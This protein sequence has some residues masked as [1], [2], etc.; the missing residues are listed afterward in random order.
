[1]SS[2]PPETLTLRAYREHD[3][4]QVAELFEA[5]SL[6]AYGVSDQP[7]DELLKYFTA[8]TTNVE[9]DVRLA[10]EGD[11][12]VGYVDADSQ[13][14]ASWWSDVRVAP[15]EDTPRIVPV[16]IEWAERRAGSGVMHLYAPSTLTDLGDAF[17]AA[18]YR[19]SRASYRMEIELDQPLEPVASPPGIE[20]KTLGEGD[21]QAAYQAHQ[22]AFLDSWEF[23]PEPFDEWRH[24]VVDTDTFDPSLW[25]LAWEGPDLTGVSICRVRS[26]IGWV[27]ILAVLR[28]WR[29]KG[30]GYALLR[31][32]FREFQRRGFDRVGLGVD[33][34]SLTGAVCLYETA[35]MHVVR[36]L[37]IFEKR[38]G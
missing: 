21:L 4:D 35:G 20:I 8:P 32:S 10:F 13:V 3:F 36:Q 24:W 28:P 18:G 23:H 26:G 11:R 25:F 37:D 5:I 2:S 15:G 16:L 31:H 27:G 29:R 22:E 34:E 19:R 6:Q 9:E 17:E 33:A 38:L 12:L 30:I 7:R 1:M 14:A